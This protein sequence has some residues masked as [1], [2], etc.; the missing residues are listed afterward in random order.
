MP[1]LL[2]LLLP[3]LLLLLLLLLLP[4]P[5]PLDPATPNSSHPGLAS[6]AHPP[7][8]YARCESSQGS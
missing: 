8:S 5:Q 1:L 6:L 3:L 2:L 7:T 4:T